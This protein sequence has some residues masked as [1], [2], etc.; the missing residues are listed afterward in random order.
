MWLHRHTGRCAQELSGEMAFLIQYQLLRAVPHG[1]CSGEEAPAPHRGMLGSLRLEWAEGKKVG[2]GQEEGIALEDPGGLGK[3]LLYREE[4][5][6]CP[7][8]Q[9]C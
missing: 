1:V 3:Q 6:S 5:F 4:P 8:G 2:V 7:Q 9:F